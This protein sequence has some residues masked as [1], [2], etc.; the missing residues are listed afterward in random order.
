MRTYGEV[1]ATVSALARG[2]VDSGL[3]CGDR[4]AMLCE[5][6]PDALIL[7]LAVAEVGGIWVGLNP[8]L[9]LQEMT[10]I[11]DHSGARMLVAPTR[12]SDRD[13]AEDLRV[14]ARTGSVETLVTIDESCDVGETLDGLR[15][16]GTALPDGLRLTAREHGRG[17]Q[18]ALLVYT[19]GTTGRPKGALLTHQGLCWT[20]RTQWQRWGAHPMRT[21]CNFPMNHLAGMGEACLTPMVGGGTVV[22]MDRFRPAALLDVIEKEE[23]NTLLQIPTMF[24]LLFADPAFHE[25]RL[26]SVEILI[27]AGAALPRALVERLWP[28]GIRLEGMYGSTEST[29]AICFTDPDGSI[30][31][32][33][34]TVGRPD[35]RLEVRLR[36]A[37]G[38]VCA[39]GEAGEIEVRHEA[40]F[41]GYLND[42]ES[43]RAAF[44][45]DGYVRTGDVG[46][47]RDD[48]CIRLVGRAKEMFKSGGYNVYPR[49]VEVAME[50]HPSVALCAVVAAPD[51]LYSEVGHA[52]V[53]PRSDGPIVSEVELRTWAAGRLANYKVPKA[54]HFMPE[55]PRLPV[56]KVDKGQLSALARELVNA[57]GTV[58]PES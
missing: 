29:V 44:T 20:Y 21:V 46:V 28:L 43:T 35:P 18:P 3:C 12:T 16:R 2:L 58:V 8:K 9:Q 39:V 11:L 33:T 4:V 34:E 17:R 6:T 30:D 7:F 14:L 57:D 52:F 41:A 26:G 40:V 42:P 48:G 50:E 36:G 54:F 10:Y 22:F 32:L 45:A 13:Y 31:E 56:G 5:T 47:Q 55:L 19:S 27:W 24:Q 37:D 15:A 38:H 49:E 25:R 1:A 53:V 51:P 23:I